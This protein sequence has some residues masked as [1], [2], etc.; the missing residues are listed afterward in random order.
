[1]ERLAKKSLQLTG[2]QQLPKK[3]KDR[4]GDFTSDRSMPPPWKEV[5]VIVCS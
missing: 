1:V 4:V 5:I 3:S 2:D